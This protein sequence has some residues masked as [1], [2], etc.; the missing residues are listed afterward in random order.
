[1]KKLI[2][3]FLFVNVAFCSAQSP[4]DHVVYP[5]TVLMIGSGSFIATVD[6][7]TYVNA[8][9]IDDTLLTDHILWSYNSVQRYEDTLLIIDFEPIVKNVLKDILNQNKPVMKKFEYNSVLFLSHIDS[10][11]Q[12]ND[13]ANEYGKVGWESYAIDFINCI[14][15]F[16]REIIEQ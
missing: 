5:D 15:Y 9:P 10:R 6:T 8:I 4:D 7:G 16:K 13:I 11:R 3:L 12:I 14:I 1:M 2:L